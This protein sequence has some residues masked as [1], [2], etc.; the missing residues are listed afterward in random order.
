MNENEFNLDFDFEK[1][2]GFDLPKVDI[3][4]EAE[5]E[6]DLEAILAENF[7]DGNGEYDGEYSADF[8][9][10]PELEELLGG[11][12]QP[13]AA[14]IPEAEYPEEEPA[15]PVEEP[16]PEVPAKPE[17]PANGRRR[18]PM[19]PMRRFKNE[20]LPLII[21]A[22]SALLI[23]IF[24]IGSVSRAITAAKHQN[25]VSNNS[26]E[27]QISEAQRLEAEAKSLLEEAADLAGRGDGNPLQ[28]CRRL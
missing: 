28:Q 15:A 13:V 19:S 18:K 3:E 12:I 14:P 23:L 2:Y 9:Y 26:H 10:G 20:K 6:F 17:V 24:I 5:E 7:G 22:V 11:P 1:E 21:L 4:P 25:N 27:T 16:E 8:D